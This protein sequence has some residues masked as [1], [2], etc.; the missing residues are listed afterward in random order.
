MFLNV[1]HEVQLESED[2]EAAIFGSALFTIEAERDFS[3]DIGGTDGLVYSCDFYGIQV[4]GLLIHAT[5]VVQAL[6]AK[7]VTDFEF[8]RGEQAQE[9]HDF[10]QIDYTAPHAVAAE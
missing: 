8:W 7:A 9:G 3:A 6:G 1:E 4:G 10:D 5:D 2:G